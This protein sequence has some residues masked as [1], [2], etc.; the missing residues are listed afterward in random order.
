[1]YPDSY[2]VWLLMVEYYNIIVSKNVELTETHKGA[3]QSSTS[4]GTEKL[5]F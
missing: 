5:N 2:S 1:M 3:I 4:E